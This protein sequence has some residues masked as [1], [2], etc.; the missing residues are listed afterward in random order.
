M[1]YICKN[2][3]CSQYNVERHLY[4]ENYR[5]ID[6]KLQGEHAVCPVCGQICQCIDDAASIPL[7]EK[8][9]GVNTFNAMSTEQRIEI[10]KRRSHEDFKRH[11]ED[12]KR[13]L[14]NQAVTEMSN[15]R[16]GNN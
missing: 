7:S 2:I 8:H 9:I 6:G 11:I 10:L 12:R 1:K 4:T 16:R 15:I 14:L 5:Y 3:Q 13:G